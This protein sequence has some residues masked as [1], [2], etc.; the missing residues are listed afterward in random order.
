ML[1]GTVAYMSPEQAHGLPADARSDVF[2]L[3]AVLYEMLTGRR[4]FIG[5]SL[6]D[7]LFAILREDPPPI[8]TGSAA[9]SSTLDRVVRRCL[10]KEPSERFQTA[11]DVGFALEALAQ[12]GDSTTAGRRAEVPSPRL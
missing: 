6:A 5:A 2:A 9:V 10:E 12:S 11:R 8:E 7:T 1:L 4:P 3:G